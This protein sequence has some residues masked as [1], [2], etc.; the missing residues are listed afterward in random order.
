MSN[1]LSVQERGEETEAL[2][3]TRWAFAPGRLCRV[4]CTAS[5]LALPGDQQVV[6]LP[7]IHI[8]TGTRASL[9]SHQGRS[10]NLWPADCWLKS[11]CNAAVACHSVLWAMPL[12]A[13]L[14]HTGRVACCR[15]C[16]WRCCA[17]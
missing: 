5:A 10:M 11:S 17:G 2:V 3:E 8:V 7:D 13:M 16:R 6:M 4:T 1:L 14:L 9:H 12:H 15:S